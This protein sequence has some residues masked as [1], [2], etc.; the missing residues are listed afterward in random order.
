[1][2]LNYPDEIIAQAKKMA[3]KEIDKLAKEWPDVGFDSAH[4]IYQED[5]IDEIAAKTLTTEVE[6][7]RIC[8]KLRFRTPTDSMDFIIPLLMRTIPNEDEA[9]KELCSLKRKGLTYMTLKFFCDKITK[10]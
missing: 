8:K 2:K 5:L 3:A 1:M 10:V 7:K 4:P 6:A 9:Q